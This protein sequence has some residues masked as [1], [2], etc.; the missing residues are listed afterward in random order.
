MAKLKVIE[1]IRK[2]KL[3]YRSLYSNAFINTLKS[4]TDK[5]EDFKNLDLDIRKKLVL[6]G[7]KKINATN[8]DSMDYGLLVSTF[9]IISSIN[10]VMS[11]LT[12]RQLQV[13]FPIAKEYDGEKYGLKDYFFTRKYIEEFGEDRVIGEEM[14]RFHWDY[15]NWEL[16]RFS[17]KTMCVMS[18][19]RRA[20]GGKGVMEEFFEDQGVTT[21]TVTKDDKGDKYL[22]NNDTGEVEKVTKPRPKYLKVLK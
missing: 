6:Y 3:N 9:S 10:A 2:E 19:I 11:T 20:E 1:G 18:A 8:I 12:P 21:Y 15:H 5:W 14:S 17:S 22:T 13:V 16:T 4:I 7:V